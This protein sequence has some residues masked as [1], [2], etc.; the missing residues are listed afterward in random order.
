MP[1]RGPRLYPTAVS[2]S[3]KGRRAGCEG[4]LTTHHANQSQISR[5]Y[6]GKVSGRFKAAMIPSLRCHTPMR[7]MNFSLDQTNLWKPAES[8][9]PIA[10]CTVTGVSNFQTDELSLPVVWP[11][12]D[13]F[14]QV[15]NLE[16]VTSGDSAWHVQFLVK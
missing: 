15:V 7:L 6:F 3:E 9:G 1:H 16:G 5:V 12:N 14:Y 10:C 8:R 2:I 4:N 11:V 13:W